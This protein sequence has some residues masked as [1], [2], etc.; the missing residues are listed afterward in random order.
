MDSQTFIS[1]LFN[2]CATG[3]MLFIVACGLSLIFGVTQIVNFAHGSFYML[4]AYGAYTLTTRFPA[5]PFGFWGGVFCAA[6]CVG[7]LGALIEIVILRRLSRAP[8]LFQ[9]LATFGVVLIIQDLTKYLWGVEDL[10]G[11]RAPGLASAIEVF[12]VRLPAYNAFLIGL[13]P[14]I[15]ALLWLVFHKTHWG[16]LVRAATED[17]EMVGALG[18]N[19]RWLF[20]SVFALGSA[21]AGLGG[22][23]QL[24]RDAANLGMDFNLLT[25]AFVVTVI[26]G[27]GSIPGA[28]FAALLIGILQSFGTLLLPSFTLV[29]V[30]LVM[31]AVLV[32]RPYGLAGMPQ[33]Q[34]RETIA[35]LEAPA[36]SRTSAEPWLPWAIAAVLVL[37]APLLLGPYGVTLLIETLIFVLFAASLHLL[38]GPGGLLSFGHAAYFGLGAYCVALA[39]KHVSMPLLPALLAAPVAGALGAAL[40]GW[41]CVRLSGV[42]RAMLTLA[43]AQILWSVAL[44]W[45]RVTGGDNGVLQVRPDEWARSGTV[46]LYVT[47]ACVG[48]AVYLL[49]RIAAAPFGYALRAGRDSAVRSASIGIDIRR[50]QWAG[51]VVAGAAAGLAGGLYAF[52]KGS[53]FPDVISIST[54]VDG[55]VMILVGGIETMA[56]PIVGAAVYHGLLAKLQSTTDY[57]RACLGFLIVVSVM[58]MPHGLVGTWRRWA[59]SAWAKIAPAGASAVTRP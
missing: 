9:L 42:Y 6:L 28:F 14:A 20:T 10:I 43:L 48:A 55:L 47:A 31:T 29:I 40:F 50:T 36:S 4:G 3:S 51:F 57:W 37:A 17:R 54:S 49:R 32:V 39:V 23:V 38:V 58:F 41:L 46:Y 2:G 59:P 45:V 24:P 56:G 11:L 34:M 13:G 5:G 53:V 22:A 19:Q 8:E 30:F 16:T 21:F 7:A 35:I 52:A 12:G 27:L 18:V 44:Q 15:L 25:E 26:G 1:L 33:V